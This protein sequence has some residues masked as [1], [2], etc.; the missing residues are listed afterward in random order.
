MKN[1]FGSPQVRIFTSSAEVSANVVD[2]SYKYSQEEDDVCQI[3][4]RDKNVDLADRPEFQ[5]GAILKVVWGYTGEDKKIRKVCVR[6]IKASF[7]ETEICLDLLCTDLSSRIKGNSSK[8]IHKGTLLQIGSEIAKKN[9]LKLVST[10]IDDS[11]NIYTEG[12]KNTDNRRPGYYKEDSNYTTAIDNTGVSRDMKFRV[13]DQLPQ[14]N[15]SDFNILKVAA[16]GDPSGPFEVTGRD[17][18]LIIQKKDLN[19]KPLKVFDYKDGKGLV[20]SFN[21]ESKDYTRKK[22]YLNINTI[23]FNPED[24]L[25]YDINTN[26]F[27]NSL[28]KLGEVSEVSPRVSGDPII[29]DDA[30]S[31]KPIK[32]GPGGKEDE[33]YDLKSFFPCA[34]QKTPKKPEKAHM[35]I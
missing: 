24:K 10:S 9:G 31:T 23:A 17:D 6:S 14:A 7:T 19:Q 30:T 22:S 28:T 33:V 3:R 32:T 18:Q 1:G 5:D 26:D 21:P 8:K 13:Y 35:C 25:A 2:F 29:S 15:M 27:T 12:F 4:I 16:K 11:G 34:G 20:L